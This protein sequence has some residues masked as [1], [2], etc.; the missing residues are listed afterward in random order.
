VASLLLAACAAATALLVAAH[1]R[2]GAVVA[3][4]VSGGVC[5][6][7]P[8][9]LGVANL[10]LQ[11]VEHAVQARYLRAARRRIREVHPLVVAVAGSYGK[12]STKHILAALLDGDGV[13]PTRKSFNTLMGITRVINEDLSAAHRLFIVEMDAYAPGEIARMCRLTGPRFSILTS[14]GPQHLE[15]FGS[16]ARIAGAL[17]ECVAALPADGVAVVHVGDADGAALARRAQDEGRRT[18]RYAL[19]GASEADVVVDDVRVSAAGTA[20]IWRWPSRD[21]ERE[22]TVPLL[23]RHQALNVAAALVMVDL[24]GGVIDHAVARA[25]SLEPVEHRLHV[26]R[27]SGP[28]TVIDDSYNANPVGVHEGLDVLAAFPG[29]AKILV[30]PGLVELGALEAEENR[31]Y[32]RHAAQVCDE[33]IVAE[34]RTTRALLAGLREGGM[35]SER[36][37]T[38]RD[39]AETTTLLGRLA[40]SGDVVLFANDLPDTYLRGPGRA[41]AVTTA[42][43]DT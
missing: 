14:V 20:F 21:L 41:S 17:Y 27:P 39:H 15:R 42:A 22:V 24:L 29:G 38:V 4:V 8:A 31:R 12:T 32:G 16:T 6:L 28:V 37:H 40:R 25:A 9:A 36:I 1:P 33:V 26:L 3:V 7:A 5:A 13:L 19:A 2:T 18:V 10:A 30:T 43:A 11:P 35:R 23:G 34:A